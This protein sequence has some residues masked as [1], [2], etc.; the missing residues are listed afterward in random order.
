MR[1]KVGANSVPT[2]IGSHLLLCILA[3]LIERV[4]AS[5]PLKFGLVAVLRLP[6][7]GTHLVPRCHC[8]GSRWDA[9]VRR[10]WPPEFGHVFNVK[11]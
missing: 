5:M 11:F 3:A 6:I 9:T 10:I 7:I 1:M 4:V 8:G 2:F